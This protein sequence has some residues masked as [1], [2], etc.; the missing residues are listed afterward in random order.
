MYFCLSFCSNHLHLQKSSL[1]SW[2]IKGQAAF[3]V[4]PQI[5]AAL[6]LYILNEQ[7]QTNY[8]SDVDQAWYC[9]LTIKH[10]CSFKP[11]RPHKT[12]LWF[13]RNHSV[14]LSVCVCICVLFA[15]VL[16]SLRVLGRSRVS[17]L[18]TAAKTAVD[19]LQKLLT[20]SCS[21]N[22]TWRD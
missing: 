12:S 19:S 10:C 11:S 5:S 15:C 14:C 17:V 16:M 18:N 21:Q 20:F 2:Q 4:Q 8:L 7:I 22:S 9:T 3:T 6:L 13:Y 1:H